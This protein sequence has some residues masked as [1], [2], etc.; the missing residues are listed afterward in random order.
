MASFSCGL[1]MKERQSN[2]ENLKNIFVINK[3]PIED[4]TI[5]KVINQ[6]PNAAFEYLCSIYKFLTKKEYIKIKYNLKIG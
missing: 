5:Q 6:A 4:E 2:W 3:I 1:S